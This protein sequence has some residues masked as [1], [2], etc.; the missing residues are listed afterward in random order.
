MTAQ[1]N[2]AKRRAIVNEVDKLEVFKRAYSL[3]IALVAR[4]VPQKSCL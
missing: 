2:T 3:L 1:T 4:I